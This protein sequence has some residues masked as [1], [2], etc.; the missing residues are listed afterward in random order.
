MPVLDAVASD[1]IGSE[2]VAVVVRVGRAVDRPENDAAIS[3]VVDVAVADDAID[4]NWP[5]TEASVGSDPIRLGV[6]AIAA[7]VVAYT[8]VA[9]GGAESRSPAPVDIGIDADDEPAD[10]IVVFA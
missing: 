4:A 8:P 2:L 7:S 5:V 10:S 3:L 9:V 6:A 1:Q